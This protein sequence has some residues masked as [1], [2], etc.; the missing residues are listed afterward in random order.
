MSLDGK[1]GRAIMKKGVRSRDDAPL[2]S[3]EMIY[4]HIQQAFSSRDQTV[5]TYAAY[6][7]CVMI[8][9]ALLHK[10]NW[11]VDEIR[12]LRDRMKHEWLALTFQPA[13]QKM[14]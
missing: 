13:A 4:L 1:A 14:P 7:C 2:R 5:F 8:E 11:P 12:P 10:M 9:D 6:M 3:L